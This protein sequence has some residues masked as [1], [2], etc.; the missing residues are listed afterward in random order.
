[1]V[2][3]TG[4]LTQPCSS[5]LSLRREAV[6]IH[7]SISGVTTCVKASMASVTLS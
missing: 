6:A 2:E 4:T 3:M 5:F 7:T 1:M